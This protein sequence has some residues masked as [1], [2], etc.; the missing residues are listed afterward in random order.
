M[1]PSEPFSIMMLGSPIFDLGF[2]FPYVYSLLFNGLG[3]LEDSGFSYLSG[4]FS[5]S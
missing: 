3:R 2:T 1:N 5:F 4:G